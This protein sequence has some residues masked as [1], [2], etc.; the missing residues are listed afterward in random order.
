MVNTPKKSL[1]ASTQVKPALVDVQRHPENGL[2]AKIRK[3]KLNMKKIRHSKTARSKST[4]NYKGK[5]KMRNKKGKGNAERKKYKTNNI[6]K[7]ETNPHRWCPAEPALID[8]LRHPDPEIDGPP[9]LPSA[10]RVVHRIPHVRSV[11]R[12]VATHTRR[13][14]SS[15]RSVRRWCVPESNMTALSGEVALFVPGYECNSVPSSS[16]KRF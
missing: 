3:T 13:T 10:A 8:V 7:K 12:P 6:E 9:C 15:G 11:P 1:V 5:E 2:E 14:Y 4:K 16:V